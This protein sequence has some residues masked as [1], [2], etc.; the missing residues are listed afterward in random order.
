M[1]AVY[2]NVYI[3]D[4]PMRGS[5]IGNSLVIGTKQPT[6]I[7]NF[8]DNF[9]NLNHPILQAVAESAQQS[10]REVKSSFVVFTDDQAPVEEIVHRILINF[11]LTGS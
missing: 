10:I 2:P 4:A 8:K 9:K 6:R 5:M 3:V 7:E 1:K 11:I